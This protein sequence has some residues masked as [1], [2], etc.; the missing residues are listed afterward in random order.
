MMP[1]RLINIEATIQREMDHDFDD[2]MGKTMPTYQYGL[3]FF[4]EEGCVND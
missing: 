4:K 1:F 2:L 3:I